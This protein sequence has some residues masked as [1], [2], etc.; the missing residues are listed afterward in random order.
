MEASDFDENLKRVSP[1]NGLIALNTAPSVGTYVS[2]VPHSWVTENFPR[3]GA[4][5]KNIQ[6]LATN[7]ET[8]ALPLEFTEKLRPTS[9]QVLENW[10]VED[11]VR[12]GLPLDFLKD[13]IEEAEAKGSKEGEG[14]GAKTKS[15]DF[16]LTSEKEGGA[17]VKAKR[18]DKNHER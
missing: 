9:H 4:H 16:K 13:E 11:L 8:M 1:E 15:E 7:G 6:K 5:E 2:W 12:L 17:T 3:P 14:G 10:S 18:K